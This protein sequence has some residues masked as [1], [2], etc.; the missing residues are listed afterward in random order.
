MGWPFKM[1]KYKHIFQIK[2]TKQFYQ[3][4]LGNCY[5]LEL[6]KKMLIAALNLLCHLLLFSA[7]IVP[8]VH[9]L[10]V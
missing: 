9:S 6:T 5:G 4:A 10:H 8:S 2:Y 7:H 3:T 1:M